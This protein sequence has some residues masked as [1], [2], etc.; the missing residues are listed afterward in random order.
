LRLEDQYFFTSYKHFNSNKLSYLEPKVKTK[1]FV[2]GLMSSNW[3]SPAQGRSLQS[4]DNS[5]SWSTYSEHMTKAIDTEVQNKNGQNRDAVAHDDVA[6][7][8]GSVNNMKIMKNLGSVVNSVTDVSED[9][10]MTSGFTI[11]F[12][13]GDVCLDDP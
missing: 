8:M 5:E 12:D 4:V 11:F 9:R 10:G 1:G 7:F 3:V 6:D 13:K 2:F